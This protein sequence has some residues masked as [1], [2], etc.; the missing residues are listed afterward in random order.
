M[1]RSLLTNSTLLVLFCLLAVVTPS[2]LE[3]K[4]HD[5]PDPVAHWKFQPDWI[6][7]ESLVARLGPDARFSQPPRLVEESAGE[8][9]LFNGRTTECVVASDI[10]Q[11][12]GVLPKQALTVS[13]MVAVDQGEDYG[14]IVCIAQDNGDAEQGWVLGYDQKVFT[15]GLASQGADDGDGMMT[16]LKGKTAFEPGRLYHVVGVYDGTKM[17]LYINGKL[18][19]ETDQQHG[20]ILY[21]QQGE[22]VLGAYKDRNEHTLLRG[23]V[24]EVAVYSL[25]AKAKWV[26]HDFE[27]Q[28]ALTE[29]VL[30][31][32]PG[33]L[34]WVVK[35]FLQYATQDG[36]TVVWQSSDQCEARVFWGEDASCK[37]EIPSKANGVLHQVRIEGLQPNTQYFYLVECEK[38]GGRLE[39]ELLTFQTAPL[40]GTPVSFA[41]ISDTQDNLPVAG[42]LSKL[43]WAQRP[44]FVLHSG[45]LVGR[46]KL[47][48]DWVEEFFPAMS[49]LISRVPLFPVLGNH[50]DDARNYYNYMALP[51]PEYYYQFSYG[52]ADFFMIDSNRNVDPGSEQYQWLDKVLGESKATWK[53]VCHHHPPYSSDENDYGDLWKTNES[54]RGDLR[55]RQLTALYEKHVVDIVWCGHIHSYERTWP[56]RENRAVESNGTIYM[57]TGGGGGSLETPGPYRPFFQNNVRRGHHYTM[58]HI[59]GGTLELK[60]YSLDD[61]LF[62][63]TTIKKNA[64]KASEMVTKQ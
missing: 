19:A 24:H 32:R 28:A 64:E 36:V 26:E 15:F 6:K 9:V 50:E 42:D 45:D 34:D 38:D 20:D 44:H 1:R 33:A 48:S 60:T 37:N 58:V 35:P 21:P 46:G 47:D 56:I 40:P 5:G 18:D 62:D 57:I 63:H 41:V 30:Q 53:F 23:R 25:A 43:A 3:G 55:V 7:E 13:A 39:S 31:A 10:S 51:D 11:V 14:G 12:A 49:P 4:V 16:Y 22:F 61:K 27:H 17:Q 54:T 59:N 29:H 2:Y 8:S 52:D